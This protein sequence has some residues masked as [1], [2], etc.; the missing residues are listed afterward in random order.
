MSDDAQE[1][2]HVWFDFTDKSYIEVVWFVAWADYDIM[3]M[4][5]RDDDTA[6]WRLTIRRRRYVD[7]KVHDSEDVR[8]GYQ[9]TMSDNSQQT[10]RTA[11]EKTDLLLNTW[12][13]T[14][15]TQPQVDDRIL[16]QGD[17]DRYTEVMKT[18]RWAHMKVEYIH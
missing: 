4:V 5:Y 16:I 1:E 3:A 11:I 13:K 7:A 8:D 9:I 6:P 12:K 10:L 17:F 18:C 2:V 15:S 14:T